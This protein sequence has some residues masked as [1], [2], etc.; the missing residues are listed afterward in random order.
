MAIGSLALLIVAPMVMKGILPKDTSQLPESI[1]G[2]TRVDDDP[3]INRAKADLG[4]AALSQGTSVAAAV[5]R[6][7]G[8]GMV[9]EVYSGMS[10]E[11]TANDLLSSLAKN[12]QS[13]GTTIDVSKTTPTYGE[14]G[15][16][17]S[18]AP[19]SGDLTG[20]VCYWTDLRRVGLIMGINIDL[21]ETSSLAESVRHAVD[22]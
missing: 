6:K 1:E 19:M 20:S 4:K 14:N 3:N 13:Y 2:Y 12:M 16:T 10:P 15:V 7:P 11:L 9:V 21:R 8:K 22:V 5:Y 18:C 17:Q